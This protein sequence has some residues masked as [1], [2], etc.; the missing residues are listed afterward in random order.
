MTVVYIEKFLCIFFCKFVGCVCLFV[1]SKVMLESS[2]RPC[3]LLLNY[4][5]QRDYDL[6]LMLHR[7]QIQTHTRAC[8]NTETWH[9]AFVGIFALYFIIILNRLLSFLN[10]SLIIICKGYPEI[11]MVMFLNIT[12]KVNWASQCQCM[13]K[14]RF[15]VPARISCRIWPV[16]GA[17]C[18]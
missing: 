13:Y 15:W 11:L 17:A 9:S 12:F 4:S 1:F 16:D 7:P 14:H 8:T 2:Q 10:K 5:S 3:R 6:I 18:Q